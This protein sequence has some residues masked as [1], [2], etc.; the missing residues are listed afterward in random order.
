M[1]RK[2]IRDVILSIGNR[3]LLYFLC[4]LAFELI[5]FLRNTQNGDIWSAA[6]GGIGLVRMVLIFSDIR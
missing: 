1:E 2:S 6:V 3:Q 4:F 5:D